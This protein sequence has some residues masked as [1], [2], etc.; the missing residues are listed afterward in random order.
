MAATTT[1]TEGLPSGV[2]NAGVIC[3]ATS[4]APPRCPAVKIKLYF[5]NTL[6]TL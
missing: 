1:V 5:R 6:P 3:L 4:T 2:I